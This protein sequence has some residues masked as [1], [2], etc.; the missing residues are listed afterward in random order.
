ME[1]D[2]NTIKPVSIRYNEDGQPDGVR[3]RTLDEVGNWVSRNSESIY[4]KAPAPLFPY[5]T[6]FGKVGVSL[7]EFG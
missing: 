5:V 2:N 1:K 3:I 7:T 4:G 6:R